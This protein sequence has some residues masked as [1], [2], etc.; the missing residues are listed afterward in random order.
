MCARREHYYVFA[1]S[2]SRRRVDLFCRPAKTPL[3]PVEFEILICTDRCHVRLPRWCAHP[4]SYIALFIEKD[5]FPQC[6]DCD[7]FELRRNRCP[8]LRIT[9]VLCFLIILRVCVFK[10]EN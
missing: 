5:I 4:M 10:S 9:R 1:Q 2:P 8:Q 6:K 3:L 7:R